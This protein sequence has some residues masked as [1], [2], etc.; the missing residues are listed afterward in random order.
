[1][2]CLDCSGTGRL[3]VGPDLKPVPCPAC[4]GLG[5]LHVS[6][7]ADGDADPDDTDLHADLGGE[8]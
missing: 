8:G 2:M 7:D 1:M 4:E 6:G 3:A 5:W